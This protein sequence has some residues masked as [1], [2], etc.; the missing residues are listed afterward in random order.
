V[1]SDEAFEAAAQQRRE[2]ASVILL[3]SGT[4]EIT[5]PGSEPARVEAGHGVLWRGGEL[6]HLVALV[7]PVVYYQVEGRRLQREHFEAAT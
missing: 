4:A 2:T 5:H 6:G 7:G 1:A 3:V